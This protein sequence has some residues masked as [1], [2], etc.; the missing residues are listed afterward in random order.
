MLHLAAVQCLIML[1]LLLPYRPLRLLERLD[2]RQ[3]AVG[4]LAAAREGGAESAR[5]IS[6]RYARRI[7]KQLT[8]V[9]E[10]VAKAELEHA[11]SARPVS[12]RDLALQ[13]AVGDLYRRREPRDRRACWYWGFY[14]R[15]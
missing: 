7:A 9:L 2:R 3:H 5:P 6:V 12:G 4:R 1:D 15:R 8:D 13:D 11:E 14:V 10:P